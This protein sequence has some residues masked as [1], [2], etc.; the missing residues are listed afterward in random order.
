[1]TSL[2]K[3][4]P[5][6]NPTFRE[7]IDN[8]NS[9]QDRN[10]LHLKEK[11]LR[12][13]CNKI[14]KRKL[15]K[16]KIRPD[17]K[18]D[19]D[20]LDVSGILESSLSIKSPNEEKTS[21]E[22]E[23]ELLTPTNYLFK[24]G[25][26]KQSVYM[27]EKS[28]KPKV[29]IDNGNCGVQLSPTT[30][31]KKQTN[32]FKLL[33]DSRNKSI[34]SNSPGKEKSIDETETEMQELLD[35]K[36]NKAKRNLCL[37]KMAESKGLLKKLQ[38]EE[39]QE[40]YINKKM[41]KRAERLINMI[42]N[43]EPRPPK[44]ADE[45]R[46]PKLKNGRKPLNNL[47][48]EKNEKHSD[49]PVKTLQLVNMFTDVEEK[50][51]PK[52]KHVSKEDEEFLNKLSP[53]LK[54]KESMLSY[55][56]KVEK[57]PECTF[58]D[59]ENNVVIKVKLGTK[60]KKKMK[61]KKL[62]LNKGVSN[63]DA[64]TCDIGSLQPDHATENEEI[65]SKET[66]NPSEIEQITS[67]K[68]LKR[69]YAIKAYNC[70]D[71]AVSSKNILDS[72][73]DTRP[74]R[75]AKR[76]VKYNEGAEPSSSYEELHIFT[77]KK[78]KH[79]V[80]KI[81]LNETKTVDLCSEDESKTKP[82]KKSVPEAKLKMSKETDKKPVKLAP[83]F[84]TK[85]Q[86]DPAVIEAKQK[87]LQSGVPEQ[88]KK[89]MLKQ[90]DKTIVSNC[91]LKVVHIQQLDG[92][93]Q[94]NSVPLSFIDYDISL[95][96]HSNTQICGDIFFKTLLDKTSQGVFKLFSKQIN[97]QKV[98]QKLKENYPKYPV[99]RTYRLLKGKKKGDLKVGTNYL[100]LDNSV[101]VINASIENLFDNPD[102]LSWSDK[103]KPL[104]ASQ[105]IGNFESVKELRKW[106][107]SWTENNMKSKATN[108]DGS[109]SS[110][111]YQSDGDS[112][113]SI[114][115]SNNLLV[116]SGPVGSGKTSSVYAIAAELSIKVIEVNASSKRTG[117]IMLQDLQEATQSHKVNRQTSSNENSQKSEIIE[118]SI[119]LITIPV[120]KRGRPRKNLDFE[121]QTKTI[122]KKTISKEKSDNMT[123]LS[124]S[125]DIA[126]TCMSL[127]LIDDAD[128]VFDQDD[129]FCSAIVQLVHSSK[130]PVVLITSTL[131]CPHLQRFIQ[132]SKI[133]N[134]NPLLPNILGTWL[135]IMCLADSGTCWP[136]FGSKLL[137]LFKGDVRKT[138]NC[139]QFY[140]C[141]QEHA[142]SQDV[143][144]QNAD[145]RI[146]IDDE[147][148]NMSWADHDNENKNLND[149]VIESC[150]PTKSLILQ[151]IHSMQYRTPNYLLNNW[152]GIPKLLSTS[153][154]SDQP[155]CGT[156]KN[157]SLKSLES[158]SQVLESISLSD[159]YSHNFFK[160]KRD[161]TSDPWSSEECHSV[162]ELENFDKYDRH[163]G[164][165]DEIAHEI[166]SRAISIAQGEFGCE[167]NMV[168]DYPGMTQQR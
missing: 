68:R 115:S 118:A 135:D 109:D 18:E 45:K 105:I 8:L 154:P 126:R 100:D 114:K 64:P 80:S 162:S 12:T 56:K 53:S 59:T 132:S 25:K 161:F 74:R 155:K 61:K 67:K 72:I 165:R 88:L 124:A 110:D 144:S 149:E 15:K 9:H 151:Q 87:F 129:G 79:S 91:F 86:L 62:S 41:K 141:S 50:I 75:S 7:P 43:I 93:E 46:V 6:E 65:I 47:K 122:L 111:Y 85:S 157:E 1:M 168:L 77:P 34:G 146:N 39:N 11:K 55:F 102:Q 156:I 139:L 83:I 42:S 63:I 21:D 159:F 14:L 60:P 130:R 163:Y 123:G 23:L 24:M 99:Y 148:S 31:E 116:L 37:Q 52:N 44:D 92:K 82:I 22:V 89:I 81:N 51:S 90:V 97:A 16:Y 69:K 104:A 153:S 94:P 71:G 103:Y 13:K 36:N 143:E 49:K 142:L 113:D 20:I 164:T 26:K 4:V 32:A 133:L 167:G 147:N 40:K 140:A 101:E 98:L 112:K 54:K 28:V 128:I 120:K 150:D 66:D 57:E 19:Q 70:D 10:V 48:T 137:N 125:Q 3:E 158:L 2:F 30:E 96:D 29:N 108:G 117:K 136:G 35:K 121:T 76:P 95:D 106:L 78:K 17:G 5:E 160:N 38:V 131:S 84:S 127:I 166:T 138:I 107:V 73:D 58:T 27:T 119:P 33:M 152:W 134:M 145:C